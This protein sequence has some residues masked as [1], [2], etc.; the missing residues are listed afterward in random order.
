[1][2]QFIIEM[3]YFGKTEIIVKITLE[4]R[5]KYKKILWKNGKI[6]GNN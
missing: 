2:L 3:S 1:M 6:N 5:K 4:K